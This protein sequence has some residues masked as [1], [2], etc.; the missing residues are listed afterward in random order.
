MHKDLADEAAPLL[1]LIRRASLGGGSVRIS[2]AATALETCRLR[3]HIAAMADADELP[4]ME[5][6]PDKPGTGWHVIIRYHQ[7]HERRIEGFATRDE[8]VE[9]ISENATQLDK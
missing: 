4:V 7:G 6:F 1:K 2:Q 3:A 8:A 5:P 9:W